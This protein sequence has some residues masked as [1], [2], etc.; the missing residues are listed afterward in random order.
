MDQ[1][2]DLTS[3]LPVKRSQVLERRP[4][5]REILMPSQEVKRVPH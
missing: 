4:P 3:Q 5:A 1:G 2:E